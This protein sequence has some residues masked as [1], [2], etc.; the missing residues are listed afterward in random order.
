M[1]VYAIGDL[2]LSTTS[3]KPMSVF[4]G[5][6]EGHF[7]KIK[8][9]WQEK[10]QEGDIVL[11]PGDI[12]W[13]MKL[14]DAIP[15][16]TQLAPLP[17]KKVFIR[18]NHDYWWNGISRLRAAA[19]DDNFFFLQTDAIKIGEFILIGSRGWT[20]P[21]SPDYTEQDNKLYLRE[22]ERFRLAFGEAN[23][24]Y[25]GEEK[26]IALIHYP[27]FN[28]KNEDTLFTKAFEENGVDKVVFGHIHGAAYFP[29]KTEK[30]GVEYIL[31]ACDKVAFKLVKIY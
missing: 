11:I 17:G 7:E 19:P 20:C 18:G 29:L 25:T 10:V 12:S 13:A 30:N 5:N 21:G 24:L 3:A 4:G 23:K 8:N 16:L 26:K 15:D 28:L 1:N 6:W 27:P 31:T 14:E 2:H 9:D 22:A